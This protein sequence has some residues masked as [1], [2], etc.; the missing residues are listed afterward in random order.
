[1]KKRISQ[2]DIAKLLGINVSTVS[3]ALKG[4][5][6]VSPALRQRIE[7][8]A[9]EQRYRPNPFAVSLRFDTTRTIGIVVPDVSYNPYA[10][11]VKRVE[12][13][14]RKVGLLCIIMDSD[15]SFAGEVEC[16]EHLESMH[17]EG[18]ILCLSQ[19]TTDFS[20]VERL[21]RNHIPLVLFDRIAD[22][23]VSS[24]AINDELLARQATL[25]LIDGGARRIAFLGGPNVLKQTVDRKHG[26]IEALHERSLAVD[27][28]LVKCGTISFNSGL[29]DTLELLD[30]PEPPDAIIAAHGLLTTSAIQA[31][32]SKGLRIPEDVSVI[33]FM[34]DW[35]SEMN[36]PR[37]TFVRHSPREFG[38]QAFQLLQGQIN[39]DTNIYHVTAN[40]RLEVR[41]STRKVL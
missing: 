12:S 39:G 10:H 27:K 25:H 5:G 28:E 1:M 2:R 41:E 11:F 32:T 29:S 31:I 33:G 24:V 15:D 8:L 26:Y 4:Q 34:S 7:E 22:I 6:G 23:E 37:I 35:V 38:T 21:R 30:L 3:R 14:A 13:E 36:T 19:E 40:A 18:I 20:H 17:V 16:L 9:H